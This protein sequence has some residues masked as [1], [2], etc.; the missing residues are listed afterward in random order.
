[1]GIRGRRLRACSAVCGVVCFSAQAQE[2]G[3][4][5]PHE[6][7]DPAAVPVRLPHPTESVP[8]E[9]LTRGAFQSVQV[10]TAADGGNILGDA[11]NE[12]S[13]TI[14]PL[15]PYRM[16][17][18]WRQFDSVTSSFREAGFAWSRDAGRTWTNGGVLE[19]GA[20]RTDPVLDC[21][22]GGTFFYQSLY[23]NSLVDCD[24]WRSIDGG[25]TWLPP[26]PSGG[27]DKNW[28]AV[29]RSGGRGDGFVYGL[30]RADYSCCGPNIFNRSTDGGSSYSPPVPIAQNPAMATIAVHPSGDVFVGG[31]LLSNLSQFRV[32]K[33]L[34]AADGGPAFGFE[35]I[36][37][38]SLGGSLLFNRAGSP[39]PAGLGGQVW[40]AS[41]NG[42][43]AGRGN[44]Y[45]L[46]SVDPPGGDPC[47]V[48]FSR[49]TDG[50]T[51]WSPSIR[52]NDDAS[53][54]AWQW[55]GTLA[56]APG[57]RVD[58][59]WCDTS[60]S[61]QVNISEVR[62][63]SS[64]DGGVTWT[65]SIV[66][67]PSFNSYLGWPRQN[68]IGDYYQLV[69]DDVGANLAYAATFN[70]EQ[71]VFFL[72]IGDYDCNGNGVGDLIDI[73]SAVSRDVN[74]N[75][76]PDE[77][78]CLG[79]LDGDFEIALSDIGLLLGS[80]GRTAGD[81]EFY[82]AADIDGDARVDLQDLALLLGDF[83]RVCD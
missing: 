28:M 79:D 77:C 9:R 17:I 36:V 37:S 38:V 53:A 56:V 42:T 32:A 2:A 67:T 57:G 13:I 76:R 11:A 35:S 55:F 27:G 71:D 18:G 41:D 29:D 59:V 65:P 40:I 62:Y 34:S 52:V 10:N 33:S 46:C 21:D 51:T 64:F 31:V 39:N 23:G 25:R 14:D 54:T 19:E 66:I 45:L 8:R 61:E 72:R 44:L 74:G 60:A 15:H 24:I 80:F 83:G 3:D 5:G 22:A 69:S 49:S 1:M 30:W 16:A 7:R 78:E 75:G 12:P 68:K 26:V 20:F 63:S 50:G 58:A 6:R 82:G 4:P 81:P 48:R 43:S 70:G 47:D 73:S